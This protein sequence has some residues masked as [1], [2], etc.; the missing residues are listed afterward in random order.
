MTLDGRFRRAH[1]ILGLEG[2]AILRW[3]W[4][5]PE[6]A[7][8]RANEMAG[9]LARMDEDEFLSVSRDVPETDLRCCIVRIYSPD[10]RKMPSESLRSS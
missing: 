10:R 9:V 6:A 5:D 4:L 3:W 1:F 8:A 2:L 7:E